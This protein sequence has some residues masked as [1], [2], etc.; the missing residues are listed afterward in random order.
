MSSLTL[1]QKQTV[2]AHILGDQTLTNLYTSLNYSG[3]ASA[4]NA[5]TAFIVWRTYVSEDE[6]YDAYVWTEMDSLTQARF[7]ALTLLVKPGSINPSK[8]NIRQGLNDIF[9]A[10]QLSGTKTALTA[11]AKRAATVTEALFTT[12][13]GTSGSPG[14]L[15][16]EG[17][18]YPQDIADIMSS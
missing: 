10:A 12:G 11:L 8:T 16:W 17:S 6:M 4:L 14:L 9:A 7:N 3:L 2:K 5:A 13:T 15:T 18:I 1:A